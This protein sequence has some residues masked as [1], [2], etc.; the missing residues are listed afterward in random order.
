MLVYRKT[1]KVE[2]IVGYFFRKIF[3]CF[4]AE[5]NEEIHTT[6]PYIT[7]YHIENWIHKWGYKYST[8]EK[9]ITK[10]EKQCDRQLYPV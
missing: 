6:I 9:V 3:M 4:L 2:G 7:I 1:V 8:L 10:N 5:F